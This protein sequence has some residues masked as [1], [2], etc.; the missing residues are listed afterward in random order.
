MLL[1]FCPSFTRGGSS[2][3]LAGAVLAALP[4]WLHLVRNCAPEDVTFK[5]TSH[6]AGEPLFHITNWICCYSKVK[7]NITCLLLMQ[8]SVFPCYFS[9]R[10]HIYTEGRERHSWTFLCQIIF[11]LEGCSSHTANR[12]RLLQSS[13][14]VSVGHCSGASGGVFQVSSSGTQLWV[15]LLPVQL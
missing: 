13:L 4:A 1:E 9:Q 11:Q 8:Y 15:A 14:E 12:R 6:V 3:L 7:L 10:V 5:L 2:V